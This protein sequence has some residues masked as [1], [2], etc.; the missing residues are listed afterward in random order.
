M[1]KP[2]GEVYYCQGALHETSKISVISEAGNS[3]YEVVRIIQRV[4]IFLDEHYARLLHSLRLSGIKLQPKL[5]EIKF[6]IDQI[7]YRNS[8]SEGNVWINFS[9]DGTIGKLE[10]AQIMHKYP[11]A[12][13]YKN[14]ITTTLLH[15]ERS[16]AQVKQSSVRTEIQHKIAQENL[17]DQYDEILLVNKD[18]RITEGSKSNLFLVENDRIHTAPLPIVLNG[19]TR[20]KV[21]AICA[22]WNIKVIEQ[23]VKSE[24]LADFDAAF[25]T[26][27]SPKVMPIQSISSNSFNPK[28]PVLLQI[29]SFYDD[30]IYAEVKRYQKQ[31]NTNAVS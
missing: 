16:Q 7:V 21:L 6:T 25:I 28:H 14:G 29:M 18:N 26:G 10:V 13:K 9:T 15:A 22:K 20:Q 5:S 12:E 17:S 23:A 1:I 2:V 31:L 3:F 4:P 24:D 19:I 11:S 27:T 8:F 30:L